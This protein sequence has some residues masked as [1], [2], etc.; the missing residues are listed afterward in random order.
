MEHICPY[1]EGIGWGF[2]AMCVIVILMSIIYAKIGAFH[3][4]PDKD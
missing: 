1:I 4:S 2:V 3:D